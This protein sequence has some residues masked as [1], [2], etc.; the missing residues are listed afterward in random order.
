MHVQT[1]TQ[2]CKTLPF[3][4]IKP[5]FLQLFGASAEL[6]FQS[7]AIL[8]IDTR[9]IPLN[10]L[11]APVAHCYFVVQHPAIFAV[12]ALNARFMQERFAAGQRR[13]QLFHDSFD[14]LG[15]DERRPLPALQI[16]QRSPHVPEPCLIEKIEVAVRPTRVNQ[17]G[18]GVDEELKVRHL[19]SSD[20]AIS[21]RG[22]KWYCIP[23]SRSHGSRYGTR[24]FSV[25]PNPARAIP[26][27]GKEFLDG[28]RAV[29]F[30]S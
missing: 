8:N 15:M 14:I 27:A 4:E 10:N 18:S 24:A 12:C 25:A 26:R 20:G 13:A 17:A 22:R 16:L 21:I 3:S 11:A 7:L 29:G 6:Y 1:D 30:P 9:S 23:I 19:T 28:S 5:A 2:V